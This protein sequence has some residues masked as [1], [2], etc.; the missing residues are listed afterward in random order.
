MTNKF[1]MEVVVVVVVYFLQYISYKTFLVIEECTILLLP[2]FRS[3][4]IFTSN[5]DF[6]TNP[7]FQL[8]LE[9]VEFRNFPC[10]DWKLVP[11]L[12]SSPP[13]TVVSN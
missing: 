2:D 9:L 10:L 5:F 11:K 4:Q 3:H 7:D 8:L 1:K 6:L 13:E 12:A